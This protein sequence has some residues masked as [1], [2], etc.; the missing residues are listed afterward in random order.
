MIGSVDMAKQNI[1]NLKY[2]YSTINN[3]K[4]LFGSYLAGLYEGDGHIWIPSLETLK[5]KKHNPRFCITFHIKDLPLA[6]KIQSIIGYGFI[7]IKNKENACV[8]T[9]SP[10]EGLIK[11]IN[12]I[13]G[14]LRTP[15]IN[16]LYLLIKWIN[17]HK[18]YDF[19]ILPLNY[20]S[21]FNDS[22]LTGFIDADG[23]FQLRCTEKQI[24]CSFVIEQRLI[25]KITN[26]SYEPLFNEIG[27]F[28]QAK[29]VKM[30]KVKTNNTYLRLRITNKNSNKI[31]INY[32]NN[33]PLKSSKYLDYLD[34]LRVFNMIIIGEHK[35]NY[36]QINNIKLNMNKNR[37]K[38]NWNHLDT[39]L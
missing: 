35:I 10:L 1:I 16:Q 31:L 11:I 23:S 19:N 9:I 30:I 28:L 15:K 36:S 24:A 27:K 38:F 34:W 7:R 25:Y 39:L 29:L 6:K 12:L 17:K 5:K 4:E 18:N 22:W 13:N 3:E 2:N 8:L 33:F 21:I 14:K 26:E 37:T 32:L 20:N